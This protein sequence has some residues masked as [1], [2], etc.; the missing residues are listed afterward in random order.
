[1]LF[2][3]TSFIVIFVTMEHLKKVVLKI[4]VKAKNTKTTFCQQ[5]ATKT[6][7]IMLNYAQLNISVKNVTKNLKIDLDYGDTKKNVKILKKQ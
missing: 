4:I 6:T 1:M 3:A 2:Y 5:I 7:K